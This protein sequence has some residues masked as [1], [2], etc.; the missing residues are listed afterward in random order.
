M[1]V[2]QVVWGTPGK[3]WTA[4]WKMDF[5]KL[6]GPD[7]AEVKQSAPRLEMALVNFQNLEYSSLLP[8][9]GT[10]GKEAFFLEFFDAAGKSMFRLDE[11]G[12]QGQAGV[13]VRTQT[14]DT[15]VAAVVPQQNF[16]RWQ[17][18]MARLT[19]PPPQRKK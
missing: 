4:T 9:A 15:V 16:S 10:P 18:E 14:G 12:P 3:T 5:W 1:E 11:L 13:G 8:Q 6:T 17:E 7:K 19:T 2:R